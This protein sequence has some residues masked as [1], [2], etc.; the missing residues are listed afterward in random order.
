MQWIR[1]AIFTVVLVFMS[2]L[3]MC[4]LR[5]RFNDFYTEYGCFLWTVV[6]IQAISLLFKTT[7]DILL[8]Y[9]FDAVGDI[10]DE[11]SDFTLIILAIIYNIV[12]LIV[13]IL[14]QLSCL[15]FCWIRHRKR[16]N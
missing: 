8:F 10:L 9:D 4:K 5:I 6:I 7:T 16:A 3:M 2:L 14:T 15:I 11:C 1:G 12:A 13:P